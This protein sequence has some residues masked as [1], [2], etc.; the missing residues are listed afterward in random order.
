M[1]NK[2]KRIMKKYIGVLNSCKNVLFHGKGGKVFMNNIDE[3]IARMKKS[4]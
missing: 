2:Q 1:T 4:F 3:M